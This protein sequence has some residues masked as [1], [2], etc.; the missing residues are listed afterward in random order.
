MD[1]RLPYQA[2]QY[3]P[4]P[5]EFLTLAHNNIHSVDKNLFDHLPYLESLDMSGNPLKILEG[6]MKQALAKLRNLQVLDLA[7][8]SIDSIPKGMLHNLLDLKTLILAD[9]HF[10]EVPEELSNSHNLSVLILDGNKFRLLNA[11]SF[12]ESLNTLERLD[13]S[14]MPT[15]K[16]IKTGAFGKLKNL[17]VLQCH[18]NRRLTKISDGAFVGITEDPQLWP[19]REMYLNNNGIH[20]LHKAMAAWVFVDKLNIQNNP[21]RCDCNI[22]WMVEILIPE[23]QSAKK[24]YVLDATCREPEEM[25]GTSLVMLSTEHETFLKCTPEGGQSLGRNDKVLRLPTFQPANAGY[26][27]TAT[28]GR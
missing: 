28:L 25:R 2:I 7:N 18:H 8:T 23:I 22:Q 20:V 6:I 26:S 16:E 11:E 4:L 9:N 24:E 17:R 12:P 21:F 19:I 10:H 15:L 13:I 27:T 3:F 5:I 14:Y 1:P